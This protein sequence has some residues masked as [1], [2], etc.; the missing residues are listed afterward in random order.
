MLIAGQG[1]IADTHK[2]IRKS[3]FVQARAHIFQACTI[4]LSF[5]M[6]RNVPLYC[7]Q[8]SAWPELFCFTFSVG[9]YARCLM[10]QKLYE[11]CET[12]TAVLRLGNNAF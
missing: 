2:Q 1:G 4:Y 12:P 3:V 7:P 11:K 10:P 9:P 8:W 6:H 5:F